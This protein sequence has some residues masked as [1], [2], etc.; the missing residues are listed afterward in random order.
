VADYVSHAQIGAIATADNGLQV[1]LGAVDG[2][3]VVLAIV[4]PMD[5]EPGDT[6]LH[7]LPCRQLDDLSQSK[8]KSSMQAVR[9]LFTSSVAS[10]RL[11]AAAVAA[12]Q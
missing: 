1:A 11:R 3:L 6:L 12:P 10:R 2:S 8:S 7:D 9:R 5:S 4:D